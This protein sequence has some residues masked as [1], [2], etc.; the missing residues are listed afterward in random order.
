MTV[1]N[2]ACNMSEGCGGKEKEHVC[3][4]CTHETR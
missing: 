1:L 2:L 3:N 4:I